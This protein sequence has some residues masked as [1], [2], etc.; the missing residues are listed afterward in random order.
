V[1]GGIGIAASY[2]EANGQAVVAKLR[3]YENP[4]ETERR[5]TDANGRF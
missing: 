3:K 4:G 5:E 2:E 1:I